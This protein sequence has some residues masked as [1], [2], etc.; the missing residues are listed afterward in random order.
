MME[1]AMRY[2]SVTDHLARTGYHVYRFDHHAHGETAHH[3][4]HLSIGQLPQSIN[5]NLWTRDIGFIAAHCQSQHPNLP[6][7]LWGHSMGSYLVMSASMQQHVPYHN[8]ILSGTAWQP[9][10]LTQSGYALALLLGRI[11]GKNTPARLIHHLVFGPYATRFHPRRTHYDWLSRDTKAVDAYINDPR[12]GNICDY[13]FFATLFSGLHTLFQPHLIAQIPRIPILFLAG[14][15]DAISGRSRR[16]H[17][18]L[19]DC[20][21]LT[22]GR[23]LHVLDY[24]GARHELIHELN[25][26]EVFQDIQSWLDKQQ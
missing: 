19:V 25:Q 15:D 7:T 8:L 2:Q 17:R 11:C 10:F 24:K 16:L 26:S 4:P 18:R 20:L 1:H 5:W 9:R 22:H 6:L 3:F 23:L 12:C 14:T 13:H 21:R